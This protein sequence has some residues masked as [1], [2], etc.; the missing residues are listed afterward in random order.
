MPKIRK[1]VGNEIH[2]SKKMVKNYKQD[3]FK[4]GKTKVGEMMVLWTDNPSTD[5]YETLFGKEI[6]KNYDH[7][8][9]IQFVCSD[10]DNPYVRIVIKG[11]NELMIE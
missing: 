2:N 8:Q 4:D 3:L 10:N 1:R 11:F 9:I 6:D 5:D 7:E